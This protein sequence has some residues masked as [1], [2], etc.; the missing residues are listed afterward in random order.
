MKRMERLAIFLEAHFGDSGVELHEAMPDGEDGQEE[1]STSFVVRMGE[2]EAVINLENMVGWNVSTRDIMKLITA[3]TVSGADE[4]LR[5]RVEIV[6]DMASSTV[7][8]LAEAFVSNTIRTDNNEKF[9]GKV[10]VIEGNLAPDLM[11]AA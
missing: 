10:P 9:L 11:V 5:R 4:A 1:Q 6:L 8:S 3:Q 2:A 7:T